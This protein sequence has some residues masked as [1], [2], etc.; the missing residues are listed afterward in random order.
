MGDDQ[1]LNFISQIMVKLIICCQK[2]PIFWT[3][4]PKKGY[5]LLGALS[6][7]LEIFYYDNRISSKYDTISY[8]GSPNSFRAIKMWD[9][10]N[11]R[12]IDI[13]FIYYLIWSPFLLDQQNTK[14]CLIRYYCFYILKTNKFAI[15][16]IPMFA[17]PQI[18]V[19]TAGVKLRWNTVFRLTYRSRL[20]W[21]SHPLSAGC[22]GPWYLGALLCSCVD[23]LRPAKSSYNAFTLKST[24]LDH[25]RRHL[26]NLLD[27][28]ARRSEWCDL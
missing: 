28:V 11:V 15:L 23:D 3:F 8:Y 26:F 21:P 17:P 20:F 16:I 14:R 9:R 19:L 13:Y 12:E 10:G 1:N 25:L 6:C 4:W 7:C 18:L 2:Y 27:Y 5:Y 22:C 24:N